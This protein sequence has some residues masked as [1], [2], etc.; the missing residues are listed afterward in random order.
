MQNSPEIY[1]FHEYIIK[2]ITNRNQY[3]KR[4][5]SYWTL[6]KL[7]IENFVNASRMCFRKITIFNL[8]WKW[9][10]V[11]IK[12]VNIQQINGDRAINLRLVDIH[13]LCR[14]TVPIV[15]DCGCN[16]C[17]K[18]INC[19]PRAFNHRTLSFH[20]RGLCRLSKSLNSFF[21]LR[22]A[23]AAGLQNGCAWQTGWKFNRLPHSFFHADGLYENRNNAWII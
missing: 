4:W 21:S 17:E 16:G 15:S 20:F 13:T 18:K 19:R 9:Y 14:Q 1:V 11:P 3:I 23:S 7:N 22:P 2:I 5:P 12:I 6:S 10:F 8:H